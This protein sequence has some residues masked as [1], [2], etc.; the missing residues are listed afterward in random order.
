MPYVCVRVLGKLRP[1]SSSISAV[2]H[3]GTRRSDAFVCLRT[4]RPEIPFLIDHCI[5]VQMSE[6]QQETSPIPG[7][8]SSRVSS[9]QVF[10]LC[11]HANWH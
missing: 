1:R 10:G 3:W 9:N 8:S 5:G 11:A 7:S 6:I 4:T 2:V